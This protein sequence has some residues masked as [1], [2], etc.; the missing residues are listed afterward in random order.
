MVWN[1]IAWFQGLSEKE[2]LS[3][4]LNGGEEANY[5]DLG[6]EHSDTENIK[7]GECLSNKKATVIEAK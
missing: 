3:K 5:S 6:K 7:V 1:F 4:G 2:I